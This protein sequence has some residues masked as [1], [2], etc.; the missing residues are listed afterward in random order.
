MVSSKD[1][2][3]PR[4]A[5]NGPNEEIPLTV[6]S[7]FPYGTVEVI[8]PKFGTF[9]TFKRP[10]DQAHGRALGR[11]KTRQDFFPN[12]GCDKLPRQCD[13]AVGE[14]AKTTRA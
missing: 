1:T 9:K 2:A 4:I 12:T 8:H 11:V 7:I 14:T 13:M 3:D 10:H 6:L 5:T